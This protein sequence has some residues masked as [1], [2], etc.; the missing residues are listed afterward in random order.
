MYNTKIDRKKLKFYENKRVQKRRK[1]N[2]EG[3]KQEM[4]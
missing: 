3:K 1:E 4:K 2:S